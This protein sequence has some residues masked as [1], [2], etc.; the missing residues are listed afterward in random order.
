MRDPT[1]Q[2][3]RLLDAVKGVQL[4]QRRNIVKAATIGCTTLCLVI[5]AF[6]FLYDD[7]ASQNTWDLP[8]TAD[9]ADIV[10][11]TRIS[12]CDDYDKKT[13]PRL[14]EAEKKYDRLLDD[15]FTIVIQ[16]YKRPDVLHQTILNVTQGESKLI[17][18]IIVAWNDLET[19]VPADYTQGG[20]PIHYQMSDVNSLNQK[21]KAN[22]R[23]KTKAVLLGDDDTF[24]QKEDMEFAFQ[25]WRETGKNRL[26]GGWPRAGRK[27]DDGRMHYHISQKSMDYNMILTGLS[28]VHV[29]FLDYYSSSDALM[30]RIRQYVDEHFNCEDIALNYLT[31]HITGCPP[32]WV[33]GRSGV[34]QTEKPKDMPTIGTSKGHLE[35]RTQCLND[36]DKFFGRNPLK[37]Q[38]GFM[39]RG[40]IRSP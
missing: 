34:Q 26:V 29:A 32:L 18:Q 35:R 7:S 24:Y 33:K 25:T 38:A 17:D 8:A 13:L 27:G 16:T 5:L 40:E 10:P 20:I 28:F 6:F 39:V 3:Y 12:L 4:G 31:Q 36:F 14:L 19:P 11:R 37:M 15:K 21:F 1:G 2:G 22:P 9:A 23:I 30:T